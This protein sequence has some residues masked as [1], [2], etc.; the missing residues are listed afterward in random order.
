MLVVKTI[1]TA[2]TAITTGKDKLLTLTITPHIPQVRSVVS[3]EIPDSPDMI[4]RF[5]GER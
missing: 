1:I 4:I 5:F 3:D 2:I